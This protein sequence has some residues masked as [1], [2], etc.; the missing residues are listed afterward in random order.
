MRTLTLE[1]FSGVV[2]EAEPRERKDNSVS[3]EEFSGLSNT[4]QVEN[5]TS[6][7]KPSIP[8]FAPTTQK[9]EDDRSRQLEDFDLFSPEYNTKVTDLFRSFTAGL[10]KTEAMIARIPGF[11]LSAAYDVAATPQNLLAKT[12]G[13]NIGARPP[14]WMSDNPISRYYDKASEAWSY[15]KETYKDENLISLLGS[16]NYKGAADYFVNAIAENAPY[17]LTAIAGTMAGI[18]QMHLLS[19]MGLQQGAQTYSEARKKNLSEFNSMAAGLANGSFEALWENA[20]TFGLLRW[21]ERLFKDVGKQTG[22]TIF[23][24]VSKYVLGSGV[25]EFN[26]EFWTQLSQDFTN[27]VYGLE[28]VPWKEFG[29]R[30][31]EAGLI[32]MGAGLT[33]VAPGGIASG[34]AVSE[35]NDIDKS[36][37]DNLKKIIDEH[38]E[39]NKKNA[40]ILNSVKEQLIKTGMNEE[41][42]KS[43]A[44]LIDAGINSLAK[45]A[46]IDPM[47][48]YKKYGL[49]IE[50]AERVEGQKR[51]GELF[52]GEVEQPT[53]YSQVERTLEIKMPPKAPPDQIMG[54]LRN[55][56]G[57]K[58]E[59]LETIGLA[60]WM[61]DKKSVTKEEVLDFVKAGGVQVQE[62]EKSETPKNIDD[63]ERL[64]GDATKFSKYTLPGGE[65]YRELLLT[66]PPKNGPISFEKYADAYKQ[67]YPTAPDWKVKNAYDQYIRDVKR[68][69]TPAEGT[70]TSSHFPEPNIL[71]HV[72][73]ND[74]VDAQ[75]KKTLFIEE[76]QSDWHQKG[77]EGGYR[78]Q[79]TVYRIIDESGDQVNQSYDRKDAEEMALDYERTSGP[80]SPKLKI[81]EEKIDSE[82]VPNAP[83]KKTWHELALKRTLRYAAENGYD[84]IAWTTGEQQA[85]RYDLS[86]QVKHI[87]WEKND[88]G[89]FNINAPQL[90]GEP[91][92]YKEDLTI[93][94]VR[95]LVGKE[96]ALK[97]EQGQGAKSKKS[98]YRDWNVIEGENLKVGGEGMRGF[99]DQMIPS[100]LNKYTKKWGGRVGSVTFPEQ[101]VG[102]LPAPISREF[103]SHS[104][105]LTPSMKESIMQG[106]PL[107]QEGQEAPRGSIDFGPGQTLISLFENADKSTF[108]HETG[109]FYL[110]VMGDLIKEPTASQE[111]KTDADTILKW[112]GA[113]NFESIT[114]EQN[115]K[116]ARGFEAYLMEG[117][118]PTEN[119]KGVFERFK[120][121]LVDIYK[122]I[123]NLNVELSPEV[124]DV[125]S[126]ILGKEMP[127]A[128]TMETDPVKK[129]IAALKE[130]K[131]VRKV[132]EKLYSKERGARLARARAVGERVSGEK[133]FY[134]ELG[135]LK[136]ELPKAEFESIRSKLTQD[137]I[138]ALF[139]LIKDSPL[140]SDWNKFPARMGLVKL[141]SGSVPTKNEIVL[142]NRIYGEEFTKALMDKRDLLAKMLDVGYEIA[143]IPRAVMASFDFSAPFRQGIFFVSRFRQFSNAFIG[144][145]KQ[146]GSEKVFKEVQA[147]IYADPLFKL[148]DEVGLSLTDMEGLLTER[149]EKFM[150]SWA[151]KIP[152]VKYVIKASNRAYTGFLN[153]LRFDVF[154]DIVKK[155]ELAGLEPKENIDLTKEIA[156]LVNNGT[157]RGKLGGFERSATA[158]NTFFFS[159]RLMASRL[160]LLNPVYYVRLNP[161]VR[162]EALKSLFGFLGFGLILIGLSKLIGAMVGMDWRSADFGKIKIRNTRLDVWGGFQQ[163]I[164][165]AGQLVTGEYVSSYTGKK[166]T[167]GEGYKP[168]T[169]FDILLRQVESKESPLFSFATA[170]LKGQD[171]AGKKVEIP[172]EI[173]QRF[174]PMVVQDI[175]DLAKEDPELLPLGALGAFGFGVQTYE[176]RNIGPKKR[177]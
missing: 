61:A 171:F 163:Y 94:E 27:K 4:P 3:F 48:L 81:V 7:Q 153:K 59:E 17:T 157:G 72:R 105:E 169:R 154:K 42:A 66:L 11:A 130:A 109:H 172:K 62:V 96:I 50:K 170:L 39:T 97:I 160:T 176:K 95:E 68:G 168:L 5:E 123:I 82:G 44:K 113:E 121:W 165:I 43:N 106:Q 162:K 103:E 13:W 22:K 36:V 90:N 52:Q 47:D 78:E 143:N 159:P 118:A 84:Q 56:P 119:L 102:D 104:L 173:A 92:I 139:N 53:F 75:G 138:N 148:A 115:E 152:V 155:A 12:T 45:K 64:R 156:G 77:R 74:R 136:G 122:S 60:E 1:E 164:R 57:V 2:E 140:L 144:M 124:R 65:N 129:V 86:K 131:P 80:G 110:K 100:F 33:T 58:Q 70:F 10:A 24:N 145:F 127:G 41:E 25:G 19:F 108:L 8:Q 93:D 128:E 114:V 37:F 79:K 135:Q 20:G 142:L 91:G 31:L 30:A 34:I 29:W 125:Y 150:S 167:L 175:Y 161:F 21:G 69:A 23:K 71:A 133:G 166:I 85:K 174:I 88:D 99:Y 117:T 137:D 38:K 112:L 147:S 134:A 9:P 76:I 89:T 67:Q 151:E 107:F 51:E 83:F 54:M 158:L 32:G 73:F 46:G 26:E 87:A 35:S 98:A 6:T 149:E 40:D 101:R 120:E 141:L 63:I 49:T 18:P 16:G 132:Q 146:F 126:R 15:N 116:F 177:S 14:L 111:L 55:T 28:N